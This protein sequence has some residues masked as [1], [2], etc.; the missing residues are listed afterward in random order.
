MAKEIIHVKVKSLIEVASSPLLFPQKPSNSPKL[1][2]IRE[3]RA[4]E[5]EDDIMICDVGLIL[6][7]PCCFCG[8][9]FT[10]QNIP[11]HKIC[12]ILVRVIG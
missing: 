4:E 11:Q 12:D 10:S 2:T 7:L 5:C 1:E 3:E 6:A 9:G 8:A